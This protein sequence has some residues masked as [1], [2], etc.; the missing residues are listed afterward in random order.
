MINKLRY[1]GIDD[2]LHAKLMLSFEDNVRYE[3][4]NPLNFKRDSDEET[5]KAWKNIY[6]SREYFKTLEFP[7]SEITSWLI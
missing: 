1:A 6:N 4:T 3:M 2:D 7:H 5:K